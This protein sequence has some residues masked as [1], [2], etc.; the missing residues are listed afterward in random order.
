MSMNTVVKTDSGA[1]EGFVVDG[2]AVFK[3][4]PYAA[5]PDGHLR[6]RAPA[7]PQSWEG[8]RPAHEFSAAPPQLPLVPGMPR[9]WTPDD[10]MDCLSVNVWT[11]DIG[12][13]GLPVMVW[14]YGGGWKSGSSSDPVHDGAM[15][16]RGGVVVVTFNYR[17]G[18]EGFGLVPGLP[19]NRGFL[20]QIAALRWVRENISRF[21]GD[22]DKVTVFGESGGAASVAALMSAPAAQGLFRRAIVQSLAGRYLP[23]AEAGRIAGIIAG[24]VG[25][26]PEDLAT[27]APEVLL[28]VQ[29]VPLSAMEADPGAWSTPE[30]I[31]SFS[32]VIDGET[33][34]DKPW[35]ALR[36]GV[37][38]DVDLISGFTQDEF[39]M[40][41]MSQ[42]V[43]KPKPADLIRAMP[44]FAEML[45]RRLRDRMKHTESGPAGQ[46]RRKAR[47]VPDLQEVARLLGLD[48]SAA[49][50]YRAAFP[51]LTDR[52]L[53]TM[54][55]SDS[56]FRM[57]STWLAEAHVAAGGRAY[58][59]NFTWRS[60]QWKRTL[61]AVHALDVPVTFGNGDNAF[62]RFMIG[63]SVPDDFV[64]L[65]ER[66]RT[67]WISFAATGDPGWPQFT[68]EEPVI[69][70]WDS[71]PSVAMDPLAPSRR[72]W[73]PLAAY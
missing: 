47:T 12:S 5:P 8:V 28:A 36:S 14:I 6:M 37:S 32:P 39:T 72:I 21:G 45:I 11:P 61:G 33:V 9:I 24:A 50:E 25:V 67:S 55:F 38:R 30:A 64:R 54:M 70:I 48:A 49:D 1:V 7:P 16:A 46:R 59:Y 35:I 40:F 43:I 57:P 73:S 62:A 34:V 26:S 3:G 15:L 53:Y 71:Q 31:T 4:I 13:A 22:P 52:D 23:P 2:L 69:Q 65:S 42:G 63:R 18:F 27:V 56:L 68:A 66:L 44:L 20:D 51:R 41:S 60:P 19:A 29:D 17:V 10:G 58:M